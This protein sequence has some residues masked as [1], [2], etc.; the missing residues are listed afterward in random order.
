MAINATADPGFHVGGADRLGEGT[1]LR[2]VHFSVEKYSKTK[3]LGPVEG[4]GD[5]PGSA[6]ATYTIK[7]FRHIPSPSQ[8]AFR[9]S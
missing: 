1:D 5:A 4:A 7:S 2:P 3:E 6:T 8:H 9:K